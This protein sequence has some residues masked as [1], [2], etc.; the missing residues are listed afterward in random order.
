MKRTLIGAIFLTVAACGPNEKK[1]DDTPETK[2]EEK[3]E[4]PVETKEETKFFPLTEDGIHSFTIFFE[5]EGR[6][7][8]FVMK[9]ND[10]IITHRL[11]LF[12][13]ADQNV[14]DKDGVAL[15]KYPN[16]FPFEVT[17][18]P[19]PRNTVTVVNH[20]GDFP[21]VEIFR[22]EDKKVPGS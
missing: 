14:T 6:L 7:N 18:K 20:L 12:R 13:H 15:K 22:F 16:G 10:V 4:K 19:A 5:E 21:L 11:E 3:V 1:K 9:D 8:L 2:Q 17:V